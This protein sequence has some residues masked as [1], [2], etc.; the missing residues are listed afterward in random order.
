MKT[1]TKWRAAV[2]SLALLSM[3]FSGCVSTLGKAKQTA[4]VSQEV[5][6]SVE[7]ETVRQISE[8]VSKSRTGA[9]TQDDRTRLAMLNDLRKLL[10]KFAELHNA[11]VASLKV[12]ETTAQK[13]AN[14]NDLSTQ[15][16]ALIQNVQDLAKRL[17]IKIH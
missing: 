14:V 5:Y 8:I 4:A 17:G 6:T 11:F 16:I 10:D 12:W 7:G 15:M 1:K 3:M 2:A 13:P 9:I